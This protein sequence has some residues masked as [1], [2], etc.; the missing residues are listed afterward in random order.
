MKMMIKMLV[1]AMV[2]ALVVA[3]VST[4]K[5]NGIFQS[6]VYAILIGLVVYAVALI[7]RTDKR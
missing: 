5:L 4:L 7:M 2:A 1:V 6:I 3:I